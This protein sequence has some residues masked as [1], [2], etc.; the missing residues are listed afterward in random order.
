MVRILVDDICRISQK[1]GKKALSRI[2]HKIV[3]KYPKSFLDE[4]EGTLVGSGYDSLLK[5]LQLRFD[6]I[7]RYCNSSSLKRKNSLVTEEEDVV[8]D[9]PTH[10]TYLRDNYGCINYMPSDCPDGESEA[11]QENKQGLLKQ[12]YKQKLS[13]EVEDLMRKT[14][15]SQRKDIVEK[16]MDVLHLRNEWPYL[17]EPVGM[18][19]HFEELTGISIREKF[20]SAITSKGPR[21][22]KWMEEE[23]SKNVRKIQQEF[24]KASSSVDNSNSEVAAMVCAVLSYLQEKEEFLYICVKV[25]SLKVTSI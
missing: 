23:P 11:T 25:S 13:D 19:A 1:P 12:K 15:F 2:A 10:K 6:N 17:F 8:E 18:F 21:I 24:L 4:I 3:K 22:L 16:K 5:Q 9:G 20:D 7:N 14:Y